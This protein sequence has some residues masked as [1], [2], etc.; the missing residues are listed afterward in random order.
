MFLFHILLSYAISISQAVAVVDPTRPQPSANNNQQTT[1]PPTMVTASRTALDQQQIFSSSHSSFKG[2]TAIDPPSPV[3]M[4]SM[5]Q[6]PKTLTSSTSFDSKSS[7]P[8]FS[9]YQMTAEA[10]RLFQTL[11]QSPLPIPDVT[12]K[13]KWDFSLTLLY[14][15]CTYTF[16]F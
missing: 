5:H 9:T 6:V 4:S 10:A 13:A 8:S 2:S 7:F 12:I 15:S 14:F 3:A 1:S 16:K 11:Q